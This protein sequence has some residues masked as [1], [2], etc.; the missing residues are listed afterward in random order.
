MGA[1]INKHPTKTFSKSAMSYVTE[2]I[3]DNIEDDRPRHKINKVGDEGEGVG[4]DS[5][6]SD[7]ID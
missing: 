2:I 1:S 3:S 7:I 5:I 6:G 4:Y